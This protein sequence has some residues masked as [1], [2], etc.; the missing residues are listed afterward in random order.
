MIIHTSIHTYGEM[1][2]FGE[3]D[4]MI[5]ISGKM[6]KLN[7]YNGFRSNISFFKVL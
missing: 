2:V 1:V 3:S 6:H 5:E 4:K 7:P